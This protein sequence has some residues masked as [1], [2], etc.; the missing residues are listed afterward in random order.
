[1]RLENATP[2]AARLL[3]TELAEHAV[4]GVVVVKAT[5]I[6]N[7]HGQPCPAPEQVPIIDT[8]LPTHFGIF[9][10]DLFLEKHGVDLCVLGTLRRSRPQRLTHV[11]IRAGSYAH[12]LSVF[13]DRRWLRTAAGL[14]ASE[15]KPFTE[16]P[17]SYARAYGGSTCHDYETATFPYN[18][19]GIGYY[20]SAQAAEGQV[21]P[22]IEASA[23]LIRSW[24][25]QPE[26][27]GCAPY[28]FYWGLGAVQGIQLPTSRAPKQPSTRD[29]RVLP[30]LYNQ[31]HPALVLP[32]FDERQRIEVTGLL[33]HTLSIQLP[34]FAPELDLC[35]GS[36]WSSL[37]GALDGI[38]IWADS[39]HLTLT[40]R[41]HFQYALRKEEPRFA[42]LRDSTSG[43]AN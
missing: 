38:Y 15:P 14:V 7:E 34:R 3:Q 40:H 35:V 18:P 9:H 21:L 1:M 31:A 2:Y 20:L 26:P 33:D 17:L 13:G 41:I 29:V 5:F 19:L 11:C 23:C 10:T 30:R 42:R 37:G 28:P 8:A 43:K 25:D 39:G 32:A 12:Q 6:W 4:R 36:S 24:Q 27:A 16:M 22:N